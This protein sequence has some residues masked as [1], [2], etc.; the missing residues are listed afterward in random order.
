MRCAGKLK[1][2]NA[3]LVLAIAVNSIMF[4]RLRQQ[5]EFDLNVE[6]LIPKNYG[7]WRSK[8]MPI[9]EYVIK[10]VDADS[11]VWRLY[12]DEKG[13]W[14]EVWMAFY[15]DQV[16]STAHN[17]NTCYSGQ[18]WVTEK[19][20]HSISLDDGRTLDM[21]RIFLTKGDQKSVSYYWY[22]SAGKNAGTELAKNM[23]KF[24][25]GLVRN[26]RDLLFM[27]FSTDVSENDVDRAEKA[28]KGFIKT[29]YP[30]LDERFPPG[31]VG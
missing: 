24:Y 1:Q 14:V 7:V 9:S 21:T 5:H 13:N 22:M 10:G 31:Y 28:L 12:Y 27:R 3:L 19:S 16:K 8:N 17:P 26:R 25:Y 2:L 29:F 15:R 6:M 4:F 23:Y 20:R 11:E 18:G 30:L